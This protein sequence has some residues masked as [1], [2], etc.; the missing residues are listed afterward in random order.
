MES[1]MDRRQFLKMGA[2]GA[3]VAAMGVAGSALA[4]PVVFAD[5]DMEWERE[6]DVIFVG[7]G[8]AG[9]YGAAGALD[10]G[11]SVLVLEKETPEN[12]GGDTRVYGGIFAVRDADNIVAQTMGTMDRELAENIA[13]Y[14]LD[15]KGW[16]DDNTNITWRDGVWTIAD[17]AGPAVYSALMDFKDQAGIEVLYETPGKNLIV[18]DEGRVIGVRAGQEGSEKNYK[19]NKGVI[20]TSGGYEC[21]KEMMSQLH[22][23]LLDFT[24]VAHPSATGDGLRMA[25]AAG[26]AVEHLGSGMEWFDFAFA[27]PSREFGTGITNRVWPTD[28][29]SKRINMEKVPSKIFVNMAGQ[30]FMDESYMVTHNKSYSLPFLQFGVINDPIKT[31]K[32]LPF[33][34]VLDDDCLKAQ[35]L[36]KVIGDN[37]WTHA[38]VYDVYDWS[39]DNQAE[40]EK[41]WI[42]KADTIEELAELMVAADY[43]HGTENAVDAEALKATIEEWNAA[44]EAGEDSKFGRPAEFMRPI[45]T[46]P[47]YAAE[48]MPCTLY[49]CGGVK[50]DVNGQVVGWDGNPIP[51]LFCAGNIGQGSPFPLGATTCM[52][53]GRIAGEYVANLP[54]WDE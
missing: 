47:F 13:D 4:E 21:N 24:S 50:S 27:Q 53:R 37:D 14:I 19:A 42:L 11:A 31:F 7:A 44:C 54:S 3:G 51:G 23:F 10:E 5:G 16:F 8:G 18:N 39:D 20:L 26:G 17:G 29:I 2:A 40:I 33:F 34:M 35:P 15:I 41:G 36:G 32:N 28:E 38:R 30:R 25:L 46:P 6:A 45:V 1:K 12:A 52:A 9:L 22:S 49:S 48:M 43:C